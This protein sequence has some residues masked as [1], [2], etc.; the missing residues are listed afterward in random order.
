MI[1]VGF[2]GKMTV[3]AHLHASIVGSISLL[4]EG[5]SGVQSHPLPDGLQPRL[6]MEQ[7]SETW[8]PAHMPQRSR[9]QGDETAGLMHLVA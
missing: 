5:T 3:L 8:R 1:V 9:T 2:Q 6:C 7:L 4:P